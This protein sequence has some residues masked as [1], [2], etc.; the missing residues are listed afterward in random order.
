MSA[1]LSGPGLAQLR[2]R[3]SP[4]DLAVIRSVRDHRFMSAGQIEGFHFDDH[5]TQA[6]GARVCRRVLARLTRDRLLARLQR[7]VGGVRA[8]S[9]SWIYALGPVGARL[10]E[11]RRRFT[12]PSPLFL[13]H[14]IAIGNAHLQLVR[15]AR[16]GR[17]ELLGV[18]VEPSCWR[19][20]PASGGNR[21][22]VR[23]DI[24]VVV[25]VGAFE[26]SWFLEIDRGTESPAALTRKCRIYE[27]YWRTGFEQDAH[28]AFPLVAWVVPDQARAR[29]V[30]RV[31]SG[32]RNLKRD[33]F[34]VTTSDRLVELIAGGAT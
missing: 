31:I 16:A 34:R 6:A 1:Y 24:R 28:G 15:A 23:P 32:S 26:D 5:S 14:T 12:E 27:G 8:G 30:E 9:A 29:R 4:R 7:R 10:L 2:E 17:F 11:E 22:T 13:D 3:L 25:G 19:R 33:L 18:E 20:Y 21:E